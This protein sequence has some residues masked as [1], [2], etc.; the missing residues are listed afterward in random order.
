MEAIGNITNQANA[1]MHGPM[2]GSSNNQQFGM[3]VTA[4]QAL[5]AELPH[6][7]ADLETEPR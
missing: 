3:P 6:I 1:F 4:A 2:T 7:R 5:T